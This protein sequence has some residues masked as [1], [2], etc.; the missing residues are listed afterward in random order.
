MVEMVVMVFLHQSQ[1]LL[2]RMQEEVVV[3]Q[4]VLT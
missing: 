3:D 4:E 1:D 2:S